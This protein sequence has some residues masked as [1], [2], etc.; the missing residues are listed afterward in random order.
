MGGLAACKTCEPGI[1]WASDVHHVV[2][3]D[4]VLPLESSVELRTPSVEDD[5]PVLV[6]L[7]LRGPL[8]LLRDVLPVD[9]AQVSGKVIFGLVMAYKLILL[10]FLRLLAARFPLAGLSSRSFLGRPASSD[11]C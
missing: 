1:R 7:V 5:V 4:P 10:F 6:V 2:V 9:A 3:A 11:C 8:A